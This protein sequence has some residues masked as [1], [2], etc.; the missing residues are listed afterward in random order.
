[1]KANFKI[2]F[3][4]LSIGLLLVFFSQTTIAQKTEN[5]IAVFAPIYLDSAFNGN[6]LKI[7]ESSLPKN[8]LPGLEFFNG[9]QMAIDSLKREGIN[10]ITIDIYDYKSKGNSLQEIIKNTKNKLATST[11]IIASFNRY[12]DIKILAD[13]AYQNKIPLISA[14]YPNDGGV[15]NNPYF[16]LI[17]P[18]I[19]THVKAIYN[20][21]ITNY[22]NT[23]IVYIKCK[24]AFENWVDDNFLENE[25]ITSKEKRTVLKPI[26]LIDTFSTKELLINLDSTVKNTIVC[27]CSKESF[28]QKI[29]IDLSNN[30]PYATTVLG[31]PTWDAFNIT[32]EVE[33]INVPIVYTSAY[34]FSNLNFN[35]S[36]VDYITKAYE[37]QYYL[38]PSYHFFRGFETMLRIGKTVSLYNENAITLF[39][40]NLFRV[41]NELK[42]EPHYNKLKNTQIDYYKNTKLYYIKKING[43]I[44][45]ID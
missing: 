32:N 37:N 25:E 45:S 44:V 15:T 30:K 26:T 31:L 3:I 7:W 6:T 14:S 19:Q 5:R 13:Y 1:M 11:I 35:N 18:T 10:N 24:G 23:K 22:R 43:Q 41:F 12:N 8:M 2:K 16:F 21:I 40:D 34:N 29:V 4:N 33:Y 36:H 17:N 9:V 38:K 28:A 42:I 39:S 20:N 27:N